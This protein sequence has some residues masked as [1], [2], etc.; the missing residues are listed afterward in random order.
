MAL[1]AVAPPTRAPGWP[2]P[3]RTAD[4]LLL[5]ADAGRARGRD[6]LA[7]RP[8]IELAARDRARPGGADRLG[9][10]VGRAHRPGRRGRRSSDRQRATWTGATTQ[11]AAAGDRGRL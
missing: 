4:L 6:G 7:T 5:R 8:A 2:L 1:R 11:R 3:D 9:R 10:A